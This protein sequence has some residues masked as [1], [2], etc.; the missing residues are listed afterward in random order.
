MDIYSTPSMVITLLKEPF[1]K[2]LQSLS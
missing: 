1:L 2:S